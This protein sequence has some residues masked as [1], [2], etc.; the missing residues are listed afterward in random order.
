MIIH[1]PR[2]CSE[3]VF[4]EGRD[5]S[6]EPSNIIECQP[7]V[8]KLRSSVDPPAPLEADIPIAPPTAVEEPLAAPPAPAEPPHVEEGES[9]AELM[10]TAGVVT[11]MYD[12]ETGEMLSAKTEDGREVFSEEDLRDAAREKG[13]DET[14]EKGGRA[15]GGAGADE[16]TLEGL[17]ELGDLARLV[18]CFLSLARPILTF[19][20]PCSCAKASPKLFAESSPAETEGHKT[21]APT[22]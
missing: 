17:E 3:A 19:R 4:L 21:V 2:L 5:S 10:E 7:V 13:F 16:M 12:P 8:S 14:V 15:A 1:T 9:F 20:R 11:L 6:A 22:L 18:S